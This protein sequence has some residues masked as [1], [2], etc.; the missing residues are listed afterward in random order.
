MRV[1]LVVLLCACCLT[2]LTM[3]ADQEAD[4]NQKP[5]IREVPLTWE[6]AALS[7]GGELYAELCA[8]CHGLQGS[9]D[10]PAAKALAMP[11]SDLRQIKQNN[12]GEFPWEAVENTIRGRADIPA[13][14]T[15][16]MPVWGRAFTD[17]RPDHKLARRLAFADQRIY[18]LT[19]YLESIQR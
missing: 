10:G 18:N 16:D 9:G 4:E 19:A 2:T 8:V 7:D 5:E 1:L 13:H 15:I 6:K 11:L 12:D 14:G 17:A 3:A